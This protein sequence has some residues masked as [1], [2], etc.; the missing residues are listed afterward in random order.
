MYSYRIKLHIKIKT[1]SVNGY[2]GFLLLKEAQTVIQKVFALLSNLKQKSNNLNKREN[3]QQDSPSERGKTSRERVPKFTCSAGITYYDIMST[4]ATLIAALDCGTS[5]VRLIVFDKSTI[6]ASHQEPLRLL[7]LPEKD[8][9]GW[10]EQNPLEIID[11]VQICFDKVMNAG[12]FKKQDIKCLGITNQRETTI[13][14]DEKTKTPLHNAI[15][16]QDTRTAKIVSEMSKGHQLGIDRFR[17][18]CGLPLS[19]YFSAPKIKWLLDNVVD[20]KTSTATI[21][22]GTVDCW[23]MYWLTGP[24]QTKNVQ[25]RQTQVFYWRDAIEGKGG[26]GEGKEEEEEEKEEEHKKEKKIE[27]KINMN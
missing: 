1:N 2:V 21:K 24:I 6:V 4:T 27:N 25:I 9:N 23:V 17:K 3:K 19:T 14:W 15:I 11:K 7:T 13:L 8:K 26:G 16:W 10:I 22:F 5:S 12:K 18:E 20:Q